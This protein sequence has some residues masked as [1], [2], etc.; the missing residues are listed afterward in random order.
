LIILF[1]L[2]LNIIFKL[3][4]SWNHSQTL[5]NLTLNPPSF[6]FAPLKLKKTNF[7]FQSTWI[8]HLPLPPINIDG[9]RRRKM[10][11][12]LFLWFEGDIKI[13]IMFAIYFSASLWKW[14]KNMA[15]EIIFT[16]IIDNE[17]VKIFLKWGLRSNY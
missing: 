2:D 12:S 13:T 14:C 17:N 7:T 10:K 4:H 15:F 8:H 16:K 9:E 5:M 3:S 1:F 11:I 6:T